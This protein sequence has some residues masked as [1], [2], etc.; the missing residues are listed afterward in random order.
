MIFVH[1]E[2]DGVETAARAILKDAAQCDHVVGRRIES[3]QALV[4]EFRHPDQEGV[5]GHGALVYAGGGAVRKRSAAFTNSRR[6]IFFGSNSKLNSPSLVLID[7]FVPAGWREGTVCR[8]WKTAF[9]T[10]GTS[11]TANPPSASTNAPLARS[12]P[13]TCC[14]S[15]R[16]TPARR[17]R[18]SRTSCDAAE[19][20]RAVVSPTA[21][22][23]NESSNS[24][25]SRPMLLIKFTVTGNHTEED[26]HLQ[27]HKIQEARGYTCELSHTRRC[28]ETRDP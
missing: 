19:I 8:A 22:I 28:W 26:T 9:S 13:G 10:S 23:C 14:G 21:V 7:T 24:M 17:S 3:R 18:T 15:I 25:S 16:S 2:L 27:T 6:L 4:G 20:S 11:E 1:A 5:P 12:G